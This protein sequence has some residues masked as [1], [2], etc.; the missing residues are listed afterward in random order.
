MNDPTHDSSAPTSLRQLAAESWLIWSAMAGV[1]AITVAMFAYVLVDRAAAVWCHRHVA[2]GVE[3]FFDQLTHLGSSEPWLIWG[4]VLLV[5]CVLLQMWRRASMVGLIVASVG[6]A[7]LL[8]NLFK[9]IAGRVRPEGYLLHDQ[10][11]FELFH[12]N[13]HLTSFPSGH[14]ATIAAAM[15]A[16]FLLWPRPVVLWATMAV[17]VCASRVVV[18]AHYPSDVIVGAWVGFS[19]AFMLNAVSMRWLEPKI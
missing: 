1:I 5:I 8:V 9:F 13:Y 6:A 15:T 17:L 11:G 18:T 3:R 4:S 16:L 14:S 12:T 7:G 19:V 2:S 10:F